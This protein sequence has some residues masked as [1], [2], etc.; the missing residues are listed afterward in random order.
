LNWSEIREATVPFP[1]GVLL[2]AGVYTLMG[3]VWMGIILAI[4]LPIVLIIRLFRRLGDRSVKM[5]HEGR[6]L[7]RAHR[8]HIS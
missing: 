8:P 3:L 1:V 4:V 7:V 5:R 2:V 6:V